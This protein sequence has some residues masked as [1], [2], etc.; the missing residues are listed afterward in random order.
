MP[1]LLFSPSFI[2]TI[3]PFIN[4]SLVNTLPRFGSSFEK[5]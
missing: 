4:I 2:L 3:I 5:F 1:P